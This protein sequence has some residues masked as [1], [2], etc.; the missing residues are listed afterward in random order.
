MSFDKSQRFA[1]AIAR[2]FQQFLTGTHERG[3][4]DG[5]RR[6]GD[7]WCDTV[8]WILWVGDHGCE[9]LGGRLCV[10]DHVFRSHFG[11]DF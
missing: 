10:G 3:S 2:G 7:D 5:R 1:F 9:T 4:A 11:S 8:S 6:V